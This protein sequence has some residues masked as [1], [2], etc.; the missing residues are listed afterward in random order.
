MT[1]PITKTTLNNGLTIIL[2]EMHHAP[3][4]CFMVWYRVGSRHEVPGITGV[5][6]WIEH[7]LFRGT[8]KFPGGVLDRL[9]SREGGHW[10]AFTWV[11]FTA[12][13]ETMP[14]GRI[15]LALELEADRMVNALM[16]E[17]DVE[18]ERTVILSE[19]AMYENSPRFVLDEEVS[20]AVFR[21][22]PYHHEVIGDM[23]DLQTMTRADLLGHYRRHYVPNNAIVVAVG[24]F[25]TAGMLSRI[26]AKFG[27]LSPGEPTPAITRQEPIQ[28][29]ERRVIVNGP[30][31]AAQLAYAFR[32][33][34]ATHPDYFAL[35]LLNAAFAGGSS[36]GMLGG[37]GS[38]KSS[39]LYKALVDTDLAVAAYGGLGPTI[40]PFL[41]TINVTVRNA[42]SLREVED[43]LEGELLRLQ[44]DPITGRELAKAMKRAKVEFVTAGESI[45]GQAQLL[46][47]AEAVVG[48]Y[49][50]YE[51]VLDQLSAVT[52]AD[53]ARVCQAYLHK[54][55][56]TVGWYEPEGN[57]EQ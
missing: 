12:Y 14:A 3:V 19:R 20:A 50:W 36:L 18:S 26:E 57:G 16:A 47:M 17:E 34:A 39:R 27:L 32:A 46:G 52:L 25:A 22:H 56:R 29:G 43:A 9:V 53:L 51:T 48:D 24:D 13:Y 21:V 38:N 55:N 6:H 45:T 40:D 49:R 15:D 8:P 35:T 10:N 54:R 30:A 1:T 44:Q 41:Y 4:T 33:P 42:R 31:D 2:K 23:P 11:D 5:S 7:M 37:G 28:R